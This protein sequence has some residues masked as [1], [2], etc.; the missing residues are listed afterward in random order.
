MG[1]AGGT[2]TGSLSPTTSDSG[3]TFRRLGVISSGAPSPGLPTDTPGATAR[4]RGRGR[5][6]INVSLSHPEGFHFILI[7]LN[8]I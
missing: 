8:V 4:R 6:M 5:D 7:Y 3:K 2:R 1:A